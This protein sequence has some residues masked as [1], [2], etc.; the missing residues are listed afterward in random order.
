MPMSAPIAMSRDCVTKSRCRRSNRSA[1]QPVT[2][3]SR[4]GGANC[5]AIVMP[6][7]PASLSVSCVSTTQLSAVPCIHCPTLETS[8]PMNQTR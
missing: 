4:S 5:S 3:T 1:T 8:A 2:P 6:M 7:A